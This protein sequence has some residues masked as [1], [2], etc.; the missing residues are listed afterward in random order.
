MSTKRSI[1]N[2]QAV[3]CY[4]QLRVGLSR[5]ELA[6]SVGLLLLCY[7]YEIATKY[8]GHYNDNWRYWRAFCIMAANIRQM[9]AGKL[10]LVVL[11]IQSYVY[12]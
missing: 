12:R 4:W 11:E 3:C 2:S 5:L 9:S 10:S 1:C 7:G 8:A 6:S